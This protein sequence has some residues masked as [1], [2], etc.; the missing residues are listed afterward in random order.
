MKKAKILHA[1]SC[2]TRFAVATL[3]I[4]DKNGM[5]GVS[6][7]SV[8]TTNID[9]FKM[10]EVDNGMAIKQ[11]TTCIDQSGK[12]S[13]LQ[14]I[15]NNE[16]YRKLTPLGKILGDCYTLSISGLVEE[17]QASYSID[18]NLINGISY[19]ING[20]TTEY[21]T[22]SSARKQWLFDRGNKLIGLV[23]NSKES[24]II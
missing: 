2:I 21:G 23:G 13:G 1:L 15:I 4:T 19:K 5:L 10:M 6:L 18:Q 20:D 16:Q 17:I 12:I 22:I 14:F 3:C 24:N 7:N 9:D 8:S 11:I